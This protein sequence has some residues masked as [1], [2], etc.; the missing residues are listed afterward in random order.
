MSHIFPLEI[1]ENILRQ[2]TFDVFFNLS[3]MCKELSELSLYPQLQID[4]KNKFARQIV[5]NNLVYHILPCGKKHGFEYEVHDVT[6]AKKKFTTWKEGKR[7]GMS[8]EWYP[9]G[10]IAR[11]TQWK[12]GL[13]HGFE[14][15]YYTSGVEMYRAIFFYGQKEGTEEW[16]W[17]NGKHSATCKFEDGLK[18][19][20]EINYF[21]NGIIEKV[22][23][24]KQSK[25]L[26][27]EEVFFPDGTTASCV[28]W[29]G[30]KGTQ[31]FRI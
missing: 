11:E 20:S 9:C 16:F 1:W 3:L 7:V 31:E 8:F 5:T 6:R 24:W 23:H 25:K 18:T 14:R 27:R 2:S 10:N 29:D 12:D 30:E 15:V 13:K 28:Y 4:M 17:A 21:S 19:G 22:T 26:G